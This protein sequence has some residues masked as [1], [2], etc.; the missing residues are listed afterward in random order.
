MSTSIAE[1][2][3]QALKLSPDERA[4]LAETLLSSLRPE[5]E[6]ELAWLAE[7]E[8]RLADWESGAV[9]GVP[10]DAAIAR[11]RAAIR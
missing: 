8:R 3:A 11:A 9:V 7:A 5:T 6:F 10:L 2:E 4:Q 1:I